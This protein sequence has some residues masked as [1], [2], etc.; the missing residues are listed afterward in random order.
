VVAANKYDECLRCMLVAAARRAWLVSEMYAQRQIA[1]LQFQHGHE[2]ASWLHLFQAE[3]RSSDATEV[4][5]EET[6][7][8][9]LLQ[10]KE[11]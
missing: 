6:K 1:V 7:W 5:Y 4:G 3:I 8:A 9:R 2:Q 11:N 10:G